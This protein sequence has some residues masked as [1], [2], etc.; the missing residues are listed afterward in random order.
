MKKHHISPFLFVT[1]L[2]LPVAGFARVDY[3]HFD[4][5]RWEIFTDGSGPRII[6]RNQRLEMLLPASSTESPAG[7]F[8][9]NYVSVC[10]LRGDFDIRVSYALLEFPA[11]NGVR[12]GLVVQESDQVSPAAVERTSFSQHDALSPG[13]V[14][15]TDFGGVTQVST[16]DTRGRLRLTREGNTLTGYYF[17]TNV[18]DWQSISSATYIT[19]D[20]HFSIAAWSHDYAFD[21]QR[22]RVAFDNVHIQRGVLIGGCRY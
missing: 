3:D 6:E 21:D 22:V 18:K 1:L 10:K 12:V 13:E 15:L 2:L 9:G 11:F 4:H 8:S 16:T 19:N 14:Y 17:D 7:G 5:P 20:V